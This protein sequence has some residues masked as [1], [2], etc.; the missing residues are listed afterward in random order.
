M[1]LW[2]IAGK[3]AGLPVYKLLGGKVRDKV[4]V[5]CTLY[6][7]DKLPHPQAK[8]AAER[9]ENVLAIHE[10]Y[11]FTI[12]KSPLAYHNPEFRRLAEEEGYAYNS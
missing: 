1:A 7:N 6:S 10:N 4:R 9:A 12:V 8:T 3:E 5:Y 11:G 2:D